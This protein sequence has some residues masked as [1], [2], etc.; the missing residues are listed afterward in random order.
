MLCIWLYSAHLRVCHT[1]NTEHF[2]VHTKK[3][4]LAIKVTQSNYTWL[5]FLGKNE[6]CN[7]HHLPNDTIPQTES[8][9]A[10]QIQYEAY[11]HVY[12]H[13]GTI[14]EIFCNSGK[15]EMYFKISQL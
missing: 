2:I 7:S 12:K 13:M 14:S 10:L 1:D 15:N 6:N 8:V 4:C 9:W 11:M 5:L 3:P